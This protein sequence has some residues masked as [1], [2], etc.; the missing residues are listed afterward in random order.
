M[1]CESNTMYIVCL[2]VCLLIKR[3]FGKLTLQEVALVGIEDAFVKHSK[4][5]EPKGTKAHFRIDDSGLF[6]VD[7][8]M[9]HPRFFCVCVWDYSVLNYI[10]LIRQIICLVVVI[11][12]WTHGA[13]YM[14]QQMWHD[15]SHLNLCNK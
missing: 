14:T 5:G 12:I 2:F 15:Q 3:G 10:P 6:V 7:K 13:G 9:N 11:G 4:D 8:V 1:V